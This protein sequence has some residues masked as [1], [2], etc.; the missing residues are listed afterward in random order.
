[1]E[2]KKLLEDTHA[3]EVSWRSSVPTVELDNGLREE[4]KVMKIREEI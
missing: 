1:M 2:R 3:C 4:E